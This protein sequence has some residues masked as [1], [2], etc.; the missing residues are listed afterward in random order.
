MHID[1]GAPISLRFTYSI[2]VA[3]VILC[4]LRVERRTG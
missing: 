1:F 3:G 2:C 4:G